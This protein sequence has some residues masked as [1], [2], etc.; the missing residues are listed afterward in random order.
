VNTGL[1]LMKLVSGTT[2]RPDWPRPEEVCGASDR[3]PLRILFPFNGSRAARA[4]LDAVS[5]ASGKR[6]AMAWVLYVRPW[7]VSRGPVRVCLESAEE[8]R[9]CVQ[10]AVAALRLRGVSA[11]GLVR[12]APREHVAEVIVGEAELLD[13]DCIAMGTSGHRALVGA[14]TGSVPRGVA[15]RAT[16][17]VTLLKTT[18]RP[19]SRSEP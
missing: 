15:R 7:D 2:P 3:D 10:A 5:E 19:T 9:Q 8:A 17:R 18:D 1:Y 13:V 6:P 14:L 11:S 12:N 4:A 16:R